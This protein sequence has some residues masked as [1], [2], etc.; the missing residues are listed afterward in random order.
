M[1][2]SAAS[3]NNFWQ[4]FIRPAGT[5]RWTLATPPGTADN[6]GLVLAAA[7]QS[8]ITGF[9][10]SQYLTF[11]PL[12][13]TSDNGHTWSSESPLDAA[14]A[15]IPDALAAAPGSRNLL[16]L[17]ADGTAELA[18]PG[19][20]RWKTLATLRS[21][22][23]TPA[24]RR[25]GLR[26][27]TAVVYTPSGVPLLA[28]TCSRPGAVG[29]FA[30]TGGTWQATGPPIPAALS[31][32]P[33]TVLRLTRAANQIVAL[34]AA[35]SGHAASLLAAWSADN[36]LHWQ[37]SPALALGGTAIASASIGTGGTA[38]VITT[39]GRAELITSS[40]RQWQTLP[41]LPQG[42]ATLAPGPG[43]S[44]DALAVHHATLTIWQLP[45]G[46][47]DWAKT[48]T[49]SVPVQYGSSS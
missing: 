39:S 4:L 3:H 43:G 28:G 11:T 35:G 13:A 8:L 2:G 32:H 38:A 21:L 10:P 48:Q 18:A 15:S 20:T 16:A 9:R 29:I 41:A 24:G 19:Y 23:A 17:L 6:G 33:V 14:L 22:A 31:R 45:P 37:L 25:C 44:T 47:S 42:T 46:G 26:A 7:G 30:G 5:T 34:L 1:G 40:G 27:L 36:G 12:S 49:I